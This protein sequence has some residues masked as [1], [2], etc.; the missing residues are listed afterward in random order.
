MALA[1]ERKEPATLRTRGIIKTP[2]K[3][4]KLGKEGVINRVI[5]EANSF[6]AGTSCFLAMSMYC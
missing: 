2:V 3:E 4:N 5:I 1:A 6:I